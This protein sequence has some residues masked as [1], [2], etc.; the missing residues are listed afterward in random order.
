[1]KKN[2]LEGL[3]CTGVVVP[4]PT[5]PE[6]YSKE[7]DEIRKALGFDEGEVHFFTNEELE[8]AFNALE[9]EEKRKW[10]M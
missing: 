3:L 9:E 10:L 4:K 7:I 2:T 5:N 1:M 8:Q 6:E